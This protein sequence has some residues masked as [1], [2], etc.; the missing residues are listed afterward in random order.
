M[1]TLLIALL[2]MLA[3]PISAEDFQKGLEAAESGDFETALK[4]WTPL[5]E[6]GDSDARYN[7]GLMYENGWGVPQYYKEA[8]RLYTLAV[9]QGH[10]MAQAKIG[11]LYC[12][13]QG[14]LAD[15]V[16]AHMWFNIAAVTEDELAAENREDLAKLMTSEDIS[17]AQA[18]ARVCIDSNYE[19][20][21]Y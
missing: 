9:K 20:C 11:A 13:G 12:N 5:A 8:V 16:I 10:A 21:G 14:V 2:I 15:Y 7:L 19:K 6:G 3:A 17:K 1:R 4:E 18:M